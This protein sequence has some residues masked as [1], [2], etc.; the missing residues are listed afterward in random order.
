MCC[1]LLGIDNHFYYIF[2]SIS[3]LHSSKAFGAS[4]ARL[5]KPNLLVELLA[6]RS[7]YFLP[8]PYPACNAECMRNTVFGS[9]ERQTCNIRG[10]HPSL[11]LKPRGQITLLIIKCF[12]LFHPSLGA[13][14][15][16]VTHAGVVLHTTL[17][18][19]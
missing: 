10:S 7:G 5:R 18:C 3:I 4:V 19:E 15:K 11:T 17:M 13:H 8:Y 14:D 12:S 2:G 16:K 9:A 6:S 1:T